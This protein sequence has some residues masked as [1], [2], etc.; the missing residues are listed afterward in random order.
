MA[1]R[2]L[3]VEDDQI[4]AADLRL[5]VQR[6]GHEVVGIAAAGEEAI[7]MADQF[8]PELVLMDIQLETA[9]NGAEAA[10]VIQERTG[11]SIVF[12]TALSGSPLREL[13]QMPPGLFV[14]KP[15]S[16]IQLEAALDTALRNRAQSPA[17]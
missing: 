11:A 12:I 6:M 1:A 16:P 5:K 13:S 7:A 14:G 8:R 3:I 15:F 17:S 4:I 9:M 2:I 10:R